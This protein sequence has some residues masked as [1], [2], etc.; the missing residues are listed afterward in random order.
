MKIEHNLADYLGCEFHMNKVKTRGWLRQPSI[1][2]SLEQNFGERAMKERFSL[3][4]GTPRFTARR[5]ENPDDKVSPEEHETYRSGVGTLLYLTKPSRPYICNPVRELSKT[6]D[7][8]SQ[9]MWTM[10]E[11]S[12]YQTRGQPVIEQSILISE[13][14]L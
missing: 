11:Q 12:A 10:L 7:A 8:P 6:M 4:P 14:L 2:K 3:T 9:F 13:L 1:I 5:L